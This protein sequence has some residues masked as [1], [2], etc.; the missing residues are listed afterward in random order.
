MKKAYLSGIGGIAIVIVLVIVMAGSQI[1]GKNDAGFYQIRQSA[2]AGKMTAIN[3][4]GVFSRMFAKM[5]TYKIS[6]IQYFSKSS[7]DGGR[8][9][10]TEAIEVRFNDGGTAKISGSLRYKL[11]LREKDQLKL[12]TEYRSNNVIKDSLVRQIITEALL[13]TATLMKAEEVYSTRRSEFTAIAE[14]QIKDGI[15]ETVTKE[16]V[17]TNVE[18]NNFVYRTVDVK[19]DEK[20]NPTLRKISAFNRYGIEII[21]FTIKEIDFDPTIDA[22]IS[23]KKEAEQQKVVAKSAAEKAKQDAITS[24]EQGKARIAKAKA[25]EEV[26]KIR[27][28]TQAKKEKEVAEL[29]AS[30]KLVVAKLE[31]QTAEEDSKALLIQKEAEAKGNRLLVEAGLAPLEKAEIEKEIKIGIA[32]ELAKVNVPQIVIG[33]GDANGASPMDA[34]GI[35]M[36]ME[37]NEKMTTA[38]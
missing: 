27:A 15:F 23:K 9:E 17:K 34:L 35:K 32:R 19:K 24:K 29:N 5:T 14:A 20:G 1:I 26:E 10:A 18:G 7:L 36:L 31:R 12:H 8:G 28:V 21:Q 16:F 4:P 3:K 33:G 25:D 22:L 37:I 6:D 13:Q 11:S 38:K 2:I 30:K